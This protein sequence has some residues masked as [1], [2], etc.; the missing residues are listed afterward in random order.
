MPVGPTPAV[1]DPLQAFYRTL[2]AETAALTAR[3]SAR[4]SCRLGC[5]DCC[6]DGLT[7]FQVEADGIR[8]HY[9]D[10]L[11][12]GSPHP[13]GACAFLSDQG[14]CRI[15]LHRPYVCRT[16][17][18][19]LRWLDERQDGAVVE[20]RDICPLNLAGPAIESLAI[21]D[22]WTLGP[23]ESELNRLQAQRRGSST[24]RVA[25]R[26]LFFESGQK[27]VTDGTAAARRNDESAAGNPATLR[28]RKARED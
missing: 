1:E 13:A 9:P 20:L 23:Y 3:H 11:R 27:R 2:S 5:A 19:P 7:V 26:D 28:R 8:R 6:Q 17:G 10:L 25:L 22:C 14:A 15:Y 4:L 16:Q 21:D 24:P 12:D 18:L